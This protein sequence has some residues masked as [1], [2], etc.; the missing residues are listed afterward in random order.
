MIR[1]GTIGC[2]LVAERSSPLILE[3]YHGPAA[4]PRSPGRQLDRH[5]P[6]RPLTT[7]LLGCGVRYDARWLIQNC[8][9]RTRSGTCAERVKAGQPAGAGRSALTSGS[10]RG[11]C[12]VRRCRLWTAAPRKRRNGFKPAPVSGLWRVPG[13][14]RPTVGL[15]G[16]GE[17]ERPVR[18]V[19]GFEG[20]VDSRSKRG[21]RRG[22]SGRI[23]C[24]KSFIMNYLLECYS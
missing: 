22:N 3:A 13:S 10:T 19:N 23:T 2:T 4:A 21:N 20:P 24:A 9:T 12:A 11:W 6:A 16:S 7:R 14:Y 5:D 17:V 18:S 1:G 8:R 15:R